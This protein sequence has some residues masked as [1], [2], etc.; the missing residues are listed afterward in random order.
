MLFASRQLLL[1]K[2]GMIGVLSLRHLLTQCVAVGCPHWPQGCPSCLLYQR[3]RSRLSLFQAEASWG[4]MGLW[5]LQ[6]HL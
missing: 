1:S 5:R 4:C 3:R 6:R 2:D